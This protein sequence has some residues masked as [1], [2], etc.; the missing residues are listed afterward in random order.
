MIIIPECLCNKEGTVPG[1]ICDANNGTCKCN[2]FITGRQC[3][4]CI[5]GYFGFPN[6]QSKF[7][8]FTFIFEQPDSVTVV[9]IGKFTSAVLWS[10]CTIFREV[11]HNIKIPAHCWAPWAFMPHISTFKRG[12]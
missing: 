11:Y 7:I 8:L 6:C 10:K 3:D 5:Y 12:I 4:T 1:T 2:E 9:A